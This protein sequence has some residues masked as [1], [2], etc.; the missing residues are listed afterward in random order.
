MENYYIGIMS[1][2]FTNVVFCPDNFEMKT[3]HVHFMIW[4]WHLAQFSI[5]AYS[6]GKVLF[7]TPWHNLYFVF[8]AFRTWSHKPT[9]EFHFQIWNYVSY[10]LFNISATNSVT[11]GDLDVNKAMTLMRPSLDIWHLMS[12]WTLGTGQ[13]KSMLTWYNCTLK[14]ES[15][16]GQ[17][18]RHF[19]IK[20]NL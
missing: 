10:R 14:C 19:H 20:L 16:N 2:Q 18:W 4:K 7:R 3:Y 15:P 8:I 11:N 6:Q 9:D 12:D 5:K 1:L 17:E 13:I